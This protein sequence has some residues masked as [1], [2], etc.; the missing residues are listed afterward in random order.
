MNLKEILVTY[1]LGEGHPSSPT[2]QERKIEEEQTERALEVQ[3]L[4]G[5]LETNWPG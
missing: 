5:H 3:K 4:P 1:L 2:V